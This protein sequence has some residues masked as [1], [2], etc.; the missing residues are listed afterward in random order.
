MI[1]VILVGALGK[2]GR[3]IAKLILASDEFRIIWAKEKE[4]HQ[5]LGKDIGELVCGKKMGVRVEAVFPQAS[6]KSV[7]I[8]FST[9]ASTIEAFEFALSNGLP[10]LSGT[11]GLKPGD[12]EK[13]K[14]G[15]QKI[16][17]LYSSNMSPG[18]NL[19]FGLAGELARYLNG[20]ADI[21]IVEYHHR[22][23]ADS[24]SGTALRLAEIIA[25][26]QNT[27]L[28]NLA[29]FGRFGKNCLRKDKEIGI[30]SVRAGQIPGSHE[31]LFALPFENITITHEVLSRSVFA[32]GALEAAKF[33]FN[34]SPGFYSTKEI[35]SLSR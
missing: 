9:P 23:K 11:T 29:V 21:E 1:D 22:Q 6:E 3:E 14:Q 31:I 19:I 13:F 32:A 12:I 33:I 28:D 35:F 18:M 34:A 4:K 15:A 7:V 8:D 27:T 5:D 10:F 25:E 17:V 16:P 20:R 26:A 2:M 24:P 30:H